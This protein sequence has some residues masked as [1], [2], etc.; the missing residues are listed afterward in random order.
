LTVSGEAAEL[1][2]WVLEKLTESLTID[3]IIKLFQERYG[4]RV[5]EPE[6]IEFFSRLHEW[7]FI[8]INE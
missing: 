1:A 7:Q 2:E 6:L 8:D 4:E 3:R 5:A